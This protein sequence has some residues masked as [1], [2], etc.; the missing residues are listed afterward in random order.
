M[1]SGLRPKAMHGF[2][3][4]AVLI[5]TAFLCGCGADDTDRLARIGRKTMARC[6]TMTAGLRDKV[7]AGIDAVHLS[8]P[9]TAPAPARSAPPPVT[10]AAS[11]S[12]T[13]IDARVLWRIRWDKSLAGADI[14]VESPSSGVVQ[15]RGIVNDL[16]RE[17]RA[18]ELAETTEGVDRVLNGLGLKQP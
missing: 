2:R 6:D 11:V 12:T 8:P 9:E 17:R 5:V 10:P 14:Q 16:P 13:P 7:S 4:L 1:R 3:R 18:I 15:L